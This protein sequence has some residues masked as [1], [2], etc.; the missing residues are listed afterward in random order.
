MPRIPVIQQRE[1]LPGR[2]ISPGIAGAPGAAI[3][4]LGQSIT[5]VGMIA[6]SEHEKVLKKQKDADNAAYFAKA[7]ADA[8]LSLNEWI[9]ERRQ[10]ATSKEENFNLDD[11]NSHIS[12]YYSGLVKDARKAK[13]E[14]AANALL[15]DGERVRTNVMNDALTFKA[16]L[17]VSNRISDLTDSVN[18]VVNLVRIGG[19]F[20]KAKAKIIGLFTAA[21]Q[22]LDPTHPFLDNRD[23]Y[24]SAVAEAHV[25]MLYESDS[26]GTLKR[27]RDGEFNDDLLPG[28]LDR[29]IKKGETLKAKR[30]AKLKAEQKV[31][32]KELDALVDDIEEVHE[33]GYEYNAGGQTVIDVANKAKALGGKEG[34]EF[35]KRIKDS[36]EDAQFIKLFAL[37]PLPQQA[38]TIANM[39]METKQSARSVGR[40]ERTEKA[41][42]NAISE[43]NGGRGLDHAAKLGIIEAV[44]PLDM[45]SGENFS[46]SIQTRVKAAD[47]VE[48]HFQIPVAPL[49]DSEVDS[50]ALILEKGTPEQDMSLLAALVVGA[51]SHAVPV[52]ELLSKK[53]NGVYAAAG[54]LVIDGAPNIALSVLSGLEQAKANKSIVPKPLDFDLE[55]N[56][57]VGTTYTDLPKQAALIKE[58]VRM[59][60]A[61]MAARTG[62]LDGMLD[63][64]VMEAAVNAVTGGII[65]RDSPG[66]FTGSHFIETP[67]RGM[68]D[69]GF[70][71]WLESLT[72]PDI[73][74]MGGVLGIKPE[75]ALELIQDESVLASAGKGLYTV[76]LSGDKWLLN[77]EG[78]PFILDYE[79]SQ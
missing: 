79:V 21:E 58:A 2:G 59:V 52:M 50:F 47:I 5:R 33:N 46:A 17:N 51:G 22:V 63:G 56:S 29:L 60:Y 24:L 34:K 28:E 73:E 53:D 7:S 67:E 12:D 43:I 1:N 15:R 37:Q 78:E 8:E 39:R 23:N 36:S 54:G 44:P 40:I 57:I 65:E 64:G 27:L 32:A 66:M 71:D 30:E 14:D 62:K 18:S 19:D 70:E 35:L 45:T 69:E 25:E 42:K 4:G 41:Y 49:N 48:A 76:R 3:E 10:K 9:L 13:F 68:D 26:D 55:Y 61:D 11:I 74:K 31:I 72:E 77:R 75:K 16:K 38:Q 6:A 20:D